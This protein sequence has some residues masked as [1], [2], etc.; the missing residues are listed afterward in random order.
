MDIGGTTFTSCI[1]KNDLKQVGISKQGLIAD[2]SNCENLIL[3]FIKQIRNLLSDYNIPREDVKGLGISAPGPLDSQNGII[4]KTP[5]LVLLQNTKLVKEME[6]KLKISAAM[7]NDANLFVWGE[8]KTNYL[9][10][11]V[12]VGLTLG[13]GL[14]VGVVINGI[15]F[16]GAHGMGSEYG[17]SP[18]DGGVWEDKISIE[19][20]DDLAVDHLGKKQTPLELFQL[21]ESDNKNALIIWDEFGYNLGLATSHIINLFDPAVV[22]LGG[23]IAKAFPFFINSLEKV[24]KQYSPSF[25]YNSIRILESENQLNSTHLGAAM[26]I[27]EKI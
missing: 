22:S 3:G 24:L 10:K 27:R 14:G 18:V 26:L 12:M 25:S 21:A 15:F 19:G 13:S 7:E 2:Y 16:T 4:L 1:F 5:N 20:L 17:I 9:D 11:S 8:W 6:N 23:G